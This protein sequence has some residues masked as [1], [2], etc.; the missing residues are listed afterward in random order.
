[1]QAHWA[2]TLGDASILNV[3]LQIRADL[4]SS[5]E[6]GATALHYAAQHNH[7]ECIS[8][9]TQYYPELCNTG[10]TEGRTALT[11]VSAQYTKAR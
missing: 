5:D 4:A 8:L 7:I 1:M 6:H 3:L 2:S 10:D 11:W 9:I